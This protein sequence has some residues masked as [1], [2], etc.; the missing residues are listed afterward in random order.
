[1]IETTVGRVL[2]QRDLAGRSWALQQAGGQERSWATSS[3]SA[4]RSCGHEKTVIML[5]K[6]KELGF[7]EATQ[8]GLLHRHR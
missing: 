4:T 1:M 2:F 5:D 3:G 8:V 6:L 7:R